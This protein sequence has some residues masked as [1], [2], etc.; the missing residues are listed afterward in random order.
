MLNLKIMKY[1]F[2][3]LVIALLLFCCNEGVKKNSQRGKVLGAHVHTSVFGEKN[4]VT[5]SFLKNQREIVPSLWMPC[6]K[7]AYY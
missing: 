6:F 2:L 1:G 3:F 5:G 7:K 4:D